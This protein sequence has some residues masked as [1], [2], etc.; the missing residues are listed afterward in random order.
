MLIYGCDLQRGKDGRELTRHGTAE[1][2]VMCYYDDIQTLSVPWHWHEE[3]EVIHIT[4]GVAQVGVV[5]NTIRVEAGSGFFINAN[6]VHG[7]W[8]V[9]GGTCK[10]H[11]LVFHPRLVGGAM[12]SVFW[13]KYLLPILNSPDFPLLLLPQNEPW[14]RRAVEEI[15][16][17]WAAGAAEEP[18]F[19]FELRRALSALI[20]LLFDRL[21]AQRP[22][23]SRRTAL[24]N[25]RIRTMLEYIQTHFDDRLTTA[26]IAQSANLSES[27]C[28][29][30]FKQTLA[31]PPT[32]YLKRLRIQRSADLLTSTDRPIADIA[33]QCGFQGMSYFAKAF[34]EIQ[35]CTPKE[36]RRR[37]REG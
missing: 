13:H 28:L 15:E 3:L 19:E 33:A 5:G 6:M 26:Q 10:L 34:R 4:E 23:L 27:E 31:L 22:G 1:L 32:Q 36:Y 9:A 2:P 30:C 37:S 8:P 18:G 25:Q 14:G 7:V 21:P 12:D 35:G 11:S 29:R 17:A 16:S 20:L 24:N